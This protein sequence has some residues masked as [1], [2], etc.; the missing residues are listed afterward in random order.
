MQPHSHRRPGRYR[1]L[2]AALLIAA[3]SVVFMRAAAAEDTTVKDSAKKAG[4]SVGSTARQV[5]GEA[6]AAAPGIWQSMKNAT[7]S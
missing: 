1:T 7:R 3:S 5:G 2:A 6:K 4:H